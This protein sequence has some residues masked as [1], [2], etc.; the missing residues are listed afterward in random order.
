MKNIVINARDIFKINGFIE[1]DKKMLYQSVFGPFLKMSKITLVTWPIEKSASNDKLAKIIKF[2]LLLV[3]L[4]PILPRAFFLGSKM[5]TA[6]VI[7]PF[8]SLSSCVVKNSIS[9]FKHFNFN[10][11]FEGGRAWQG[12]QGE[13]GQ[14]KDEQ[15]K[16]I[17]EKEGAIRMRGWKRKIEGREKK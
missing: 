4:A 1:S 13:T 8:S 12:D 3:V 7:I 6:T 2:I 17:Q 11:P 9:F 10:G 16:G 15:R 14:I 5:G